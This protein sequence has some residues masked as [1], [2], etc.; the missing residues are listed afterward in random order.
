[1]SLACSPGADALTK[2]F[3]EIGV[4]SGASAPAVLFAQAVDENAY[5]FW[6]TR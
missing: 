2:L 4:A 1:M 5:M 3:F 6:H